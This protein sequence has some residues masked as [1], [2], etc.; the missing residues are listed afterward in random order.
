M[1]GICRNC[2]EAI[3]NG[4]HCGC[5]VNTDAVEAFISKGDKGRGTATPNTEV[6]VSGPSA[7]DE[8][9]AIGPGAGTPIPSPA[10]QGNQ[11]GDEITTIEAEVADLKAEVKR[12]EG[13]IDLL[14]KERKSTS[15]PEWYS[16][17]IDQF[18]GANDPDAPGC[19][20]G[21]YLHLLTWCVFGFAWLPVGYVLW[22][23]RRPERAAWDKVLVRETN[24]KVNDR[25]KAQ[26]NRRTALL[27]RIDDLKIRLKGFVGKG[28]PPTWTD[29]PTASARATLAGAMAGLGQLPR[30]LVD[31]VPVGTCPN[32]KQNWARES[33]GE[34]MVE[35]KFTSG[36][37]AP[38]SDDVE[39]DI[40][41]FVTRLV[42]YDE[43]YRCRKCSHRWRVGKV[44]RTTHADLCPACFREGTTELARTE[45]V[46]TVDHFKTEMVMDAVHVDRNK[47][48]AGATYREAKVPLRT[49]RFRHFHRCKACDRG[50]STAS[51][52]TYR[53]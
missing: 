49:V 50:W 24:R 47:E 16:F 33:D 27:G 51:T 31:S 25:I 2:G 19:P 21:L 18:N 1:L 22:L 53:T 3:T 8:E 48:L 12:T 43:R 15:S 44:R 52:K 37:S 28:Y 5:G 40:S 32:C 45:E 6:D 39:R 23:T 34:E 17:A 35:T 11:A 7:G 36:L 29:D 42:R 4:F 26:R 38:R 14:F 10:S 13:E 41:G 9:V 30:R 20:C 46:G